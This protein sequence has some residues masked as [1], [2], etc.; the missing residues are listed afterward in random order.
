MAMKRNGGF[1]VALALVAGTALGYFLAPGDG[2]AAVPEDDAPAAKPMIG[3]VGEAATIRSLR[4]RIRDLERQLGSPREHGHEGEKIRTEERPQPAQTNANVF[5]SHRDFV[6]K[7]KKNDPKRYAQMTNDMARW[8][9]ERFNRAAS[10]ID[11]LAAIDT[12]RWPQESKELHE[13]YQDL[14]VRREELQ[15]ALS[16][17]FGTDEERRAAGE[18]MREVWR[19][20]RE[21]E[22]FERETLL[23]ES[24]R[25]A[26]LKGEALEEV[27]DSI[28]TVY[29]MTTDFMPPRPPRVGGRGGAR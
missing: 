6:E 12:S 21:I 26:G 5:T 9:T 18:E 27:V 19:R 7:M 23:K 13:E 28:Q 10:R 2:S 1:L 24:V 25:A 17:E 4:A 8:R 3:D 29:E 16:P 11:T 14:L 15:D 20:M 22:G